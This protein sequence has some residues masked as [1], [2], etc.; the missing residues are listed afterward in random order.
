MPGKA[1]KQQ[2]K[3]KAKLVLVATPGRVPGLRVKNR[4]RQPMK[5]AQNP[6]PLVQ[7]GALSVSAPVAVGKI[8]RSERPRMRTLSNG[9][10]VITHREYIAD[11]V[12]TGATTFSV[13]QYSCNPGLSTTFPWLS[14]VASN[15]ESY[16]FERLNFEY[17][18]DI[19]TATA[20]TAIMGMDY[21]AA[22]PAPTTKTQ[23]LSYR[24]A[25]RS[26]V[27]Q[28]CCMV[29]LNED[30]NK[31]KSFYIRRGTLAANLDIKTYD[32]GNLFM[33]TVS[34]AATIGELYVEYTVR[35]MTPHLGSVAIGNALYATYGGSSNS[36]PFGTVASG[37][38]NA[39]LTVAS[40]GTTTSVTTWTAT[41]AYNCLFS[42]VV[43][44]TG[45]TAVNFTGTA[46]LTGSSGAINS[47]QTASLN[48]VEVQ[49][50]VGQ[51]LVLTASNTTIGG[52]SGYFG[53]YQA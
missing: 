41:A 20:G 51:T 48:S 39:P 40:T 32:T 38:S 29:S 53:Q 27:W 6:R 31:L 11:V 3:K 13:V 50:A 5:L 16:R 8:R 1:G 24:G 2:S 21:D 44:G 25:V 12:A 19:S 33:C 52:A 43:S 15:F 14:S 4:P 28:P 42:S 45:V 10:C 35:L 23:V 22:D 49:F 46:T 9:D 26:P 37:T 18:T 47:G 30:L 34:P 7:G 17:E 36:A